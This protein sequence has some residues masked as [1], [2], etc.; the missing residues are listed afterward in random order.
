MVVAIDATPLSVSSGG[1]RRYTEQLVRALAE[2]WPDDRYHLVSDQPFDTPGGLPENVSVHANAASSLIDRR[3]WA[4]GLPRFLSRME[5]DV[6]HGTDFSVPYI[7]L[8]PSVLT[9]QDLSPWM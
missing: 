6:F 4:I 7:P 9:L 2:Y 8:L 1:V 3:W 5:C